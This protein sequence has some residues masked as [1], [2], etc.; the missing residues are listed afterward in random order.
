ME[1]G[2]RFKKLEDMQTTLLLFQQYEESTLLYLCQRVQG[3][4]CLH[5]TNIKASTLL[6]KP[7]FHDTLRTHAVTPLFTSTVYST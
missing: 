5:C 4:M 2:G 6:S 7:C 1:A 3:N